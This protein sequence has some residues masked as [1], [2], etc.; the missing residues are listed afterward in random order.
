MK[1][2]NVFITVLVLGLFSK[3]C[4]A[5]NKTGLV[6]L[7]YDDTG[8]SRVSSVWYLE[9]LDSGK[10]NWPDKNDFSAHWSGYL[11]VPADEEVSF[12]AEADDEIQ[13][14]INDQ[15]ILDTWDDAKRVDGKFLFIKDRLYPVSLIYRQI[16]GASHMRIFWVQDGQPRQIIPVSAFS[17]DEKMESEI[18]SKFEA[19]INVDMSGL[20]F[21]IASII[22]IKKPED[23]I[24]KRTAVINVLWGDEG[25]PF[26]KLP[27]SVITA[28]RDT[29]FVNL[30]N[31]KQIDK[32]SIEMDAGFNS[33]VYHFI[34]EK[35]NGSALI[36][37]Q[38]HGGK[39]NIGINTIRAF[40]DKGYN[41]FALS[42]PLL[43][44]NRKPVVDTRRFGKLLIH[45]H[46][47][48]MLVAPQPG[49]PVKYFMEPVAVVVNYAQ[50][51]NFNRLIMAGLS[52]GGW[53]TTLYSAIDPRIDISYPVAGTLPHYLR[54]RDFG[55][56]GSIG[57]YEQSAVEIYRAA[58][59]LELYIMAAYGSDRRQLQILN[60]FDSCCFRG[61]G[62]ET[63]LEIVKERL[64]V[65]GA[66]HFDVFL[67]STHRKHQ[68]SPA[69]LQAIFNDLEGQ[70]K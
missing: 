49:H 12:Y 63:Y 7:L 47:Q 20:D 17:Y 24:S 54:A 57:D 31:L 66:G 64:K 59:Y 25:F 38:G 52:G 56:S 21:D 28:I 68:I 27:D 13:L 30:N 45:A 70:Q 18:L 2:F 36:Y 48:M 40:L 22:D 3:E 34:P 39:F 58:N 46:N 14:K 37:H 5:Q 44:M 62:Y 6:G 9:S 26:N 4:M 43:G 8:L 50:K 42:M 1:Y 32:L 29:D 10:A 60:E 65:I 11:K 23:I 33:V 41:V 55:G 16:N 19:K 15:I 67:D 51:F 61:T 69:A 35:A 53:T